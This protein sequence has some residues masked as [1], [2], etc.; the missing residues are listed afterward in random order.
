MVVRI[1]FNKKPLQIHKAIIEPKFNSKTVLVNDPWEY[2]EM[3]LKRNCTNTD[4]IFYWQQAK[5]FFNASRL[6]PLTSA[7]LTLYYCFLN[8]VKTLLVVKNINFAEKH[9]VGGYT[10]RVG[11]GLSREIVKF[12]GS[13]IL[14]S[15]CSHLEEDV[16]PVEYTLKNLLYNLPYIHRAY[17]LTYTSENELFIPISS[18]YF[19]KNKYKESWLTAEIDP[20]YG[21]RHTVNKLPDGYKQDTFYTNKW[22]IKRNKKFT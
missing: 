6:L 12:R 2:V 21:N 11:S 18:P 13:G 8:A 3:W 5:E 14:T 19:V 22:V 4:A 9:G 16:Q 20:K 17:A 15:L 10:K 1:E 7:P